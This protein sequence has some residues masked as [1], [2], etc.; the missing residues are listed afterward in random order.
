MTS[1][2]HFSNGFERI[3]TAR[4]AAFSDGWPVASAPWLEADDPAGQPMILPQRPGRAVPRIALDI[5][6]GKIRPGIDFTFIDYLGL[7]S[8]PA[9]RE[10]AQTTIENCAAP[11]AGCPRSASARQET[12]ALQAE[13]AEFLQLPHVLLYSLGRT[14]CCGAIG[15][16]VR[17]AD[18]VVFDTLI[19]GSF[20]EAAAAT[21]RHVHV[22]R[23]LDV[24]HVAEVLREIRT[25]ESRRQILVVTEALFATEADTAD[26]AAL[27]A[28]C[29][30]HDALLC[31]S[32]S[33]DL[34]AVGPG[35][36]G[37]L[38]LQHMLG[39]V[40]LVVGSF[41]PT[42]ACSGGFAATQRREVYDRLNFYT[43]T[44]MDSSALTP[45]Q[46]ATALAALRLVR[47]PEGER[48][49]RALFAAV[50]A[51]RAGLTFLGGIVMGAAAPMVPLWLGREE[52]GR[53]A[54]RLCAERGVQVP[55]LEHPEVPMGAARLQLHL[56]ATYNS[57]QCLAATACIAE[58]VNEAERYDHSD[59]AYAVGS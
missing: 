32:V 45:V 1:S 47:S 33:N 59:L 34:G 31:V 53:M 26:L 48:R 40:D 57:D 39:Q 5:Y 29:R 36:T 8:H 11:P 41:F 52:V 23:H 42:L 54:A 21:T 6:G 20:Y 27:Q 18:H 44:S 9:V 17:A 4:S 24:E 56:M 12:A 43:A 50:A 30:R 10:A 46:S 37:C 15:S 3:S 16:L 22:C 28:T 38:G 7:M 14:A 2:L 19:H 49:R 13:L 51:V 25:R 58:A 55:L 35:G